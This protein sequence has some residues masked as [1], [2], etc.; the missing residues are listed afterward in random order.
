MQ[1]VVGEQGLLDVAGVQRRREPAVGLAHGGDVGVGQSGH[2]LADGDLVHRGDHVAGVPDLPG[3]ERAHD[4]GAARLG[5]DQAALR[6]T[7]Q[8]LADRA[9][10]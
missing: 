1:L 3:V 10:G 6:E 8:R 9:S 2:R 4:R 5:L 7:Q